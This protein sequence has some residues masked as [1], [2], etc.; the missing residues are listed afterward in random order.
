MLSTTIESPTKQYAMSNDNVY[1]LKQPE[2]ITTDALI[3]L[4][5][6]GVKALISQAVNAELEALLAH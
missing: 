6:L 4:L 3:E 1:Q 5:R 2:E